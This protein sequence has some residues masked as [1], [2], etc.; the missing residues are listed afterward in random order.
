M[1]GRNV[2][3]ALVILIVAAVTQLILVDMQGRMSDLEFAAKTRDA[4]SW[5]IILTLIYKQFIVLMMVITPG[6]RGLD[7][8]FIWH[9]QAVAFLFIY[10]WISIE[11]GTILLEHIVV[12]SWI[13]FNI[14]ID[15]A[16]SAGFVVYY[17]WIERVS[18]LIH[19]IR[20]FGWPGWKVASCVLRGVPSSTTEE[21]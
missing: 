2:K 13:W 17:L 12:A 11:H 1:N 8:S 10:A 5:G 7:R 20:S 18:P 19:V 15:V 3:I 16:L 9:T 14:W 21:G 4:F 6:K